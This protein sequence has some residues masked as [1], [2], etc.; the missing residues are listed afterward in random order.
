MLGFLS[1]FGLA[2]LRCAAANQSE[3]GFQSGCTPPDFSLLLTLAAVAVAGGVATGFV[4]MRRP[5]AAQAKRR[6]ASS[7]D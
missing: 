1:A 2:N 4:A 7:P 6:A 5:S 3:L